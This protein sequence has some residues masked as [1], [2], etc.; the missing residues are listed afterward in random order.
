[1]MQAPNFVHNFSI[2]QLFKTT[3]WPPKI[4]K[5]RPFFKMAARQGF[6]VG[7]MC[8]WSCFDAFILVLHA[9]GRV[10]KHEQNVFMLNVS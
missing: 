9:Q 3:G 8:L 6:N 10:N 4:S 1:M 7:L 2:E 5:W